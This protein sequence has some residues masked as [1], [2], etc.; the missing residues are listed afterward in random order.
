MD[1]II[2]TNEYVTSNPDPVL[3]DFI[4][5]VQWKR[6][7]NIIEYILLKRKGIDIYYGQ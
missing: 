5:K 1:T 6:V 3:I 2:I 4:D 7:S